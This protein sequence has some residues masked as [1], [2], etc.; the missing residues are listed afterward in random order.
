M[1]ETHIYIV[2]SKIALHGGVEKVGRSPFSKFLC[3]AIVLKW[4]KFAFGK[5]GPFFKES[6][7]RY[8]IHF[9]LLP[10]VKFLFVLQQVL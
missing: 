5:I 10:R 6:F 3:L 4:A 2:M 8:S 9:F 1:P 7:H